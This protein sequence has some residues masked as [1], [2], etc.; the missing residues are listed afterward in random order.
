[1]PENIRQHS[2]AVE[3]VAVFLAGKMRQNGIAVDVSI[4][5]AGALLHDIG[6]MLSFK[7]G[8][9]E[10]L[11]SKELLEKEGLRAIALI[12]ERHMLSKIL[13]GDFHEWAVEEKIVYY[14]D[15]R[16]KHSSIVGVNERVSDLIERYSGSAGIIKDCLPMVLLLEKELLAMAGTDSSLEGMV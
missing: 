13:E 7:Q 9:E 10:N 1:M 2:L 5:S 11:V 4:V 6:K 8:R 15:K 3:K 16:V 14:A 12:A